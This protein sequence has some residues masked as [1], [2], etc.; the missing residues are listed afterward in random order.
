MQPT[1]SIPEKEN[2]VE[3]LYIN[4]NLWLPAVGGT[5]VIPES[6]RRKPE[7][8]RHSDCLAPLG[9]LI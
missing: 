8:V 6:G 9:A 4:R 7:G 3:K 5:D 1:Q 2:P